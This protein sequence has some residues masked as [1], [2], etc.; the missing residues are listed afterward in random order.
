MKR[1][2]LL[3]GSIVE[4]VGQ[5][6][7]DYI[8]KHV[9]N[10]SEMIIYVGSDS[11]QH[12]RTTMYATTIVFYH[13]GKGAHIIFARTKIPKVR[14]LFTR[15][16]NEVEMTREAAEELHNE[17]LGS[18][19][20]RWTKDNIWVELGGVYVENLRRA[21]NESGTN[22]LG[23]LV[24]KYNKDLLH[25]KTVTCDIDIS[26]NKLY[27]S[28]IVHDAGIGVLKGNGFRVRSKPT[29]FAATSAADLL[30]K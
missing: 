11:K 22:K 5:Y 29:A 15:L 3:G 26:P 21:D 4:D 9:E 23:E 19:H 20:F 27:K 13:V 17:L 10:H 24:D 18:Y 30:C 14:D 7:R 8:K 12:R 1:F 25:E 6:A 28:H 2:K 16:Y